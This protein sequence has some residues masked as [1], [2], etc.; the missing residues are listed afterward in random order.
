MTSV[1]W[2]WSYL[3]SGWETRNEST[4][5]SGGGKPSADAR[6]CA[7]P[8][9]GWSAGPLQRGLGMRW[10]DDAECLDEFESGVVGTE[11]EVHPAAV[12]HNRRSISSRLAATPPAVAATR[13]HR[14]RCTG[15]RPL[16]HG[17]NASRASAAACRAARRR[18]QRF[19]DRP[20]SVGHRRRVHRATMSTRR[21]GRARRAWRDRR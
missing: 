12:G 20:L 17:G 14:A 5:R 4:F 18:Q 1:E 7:R 2:P 3:T 16:S 8:G 10:V 19:E 6:R 9:V 21:V 15:W 11:A 13:Y